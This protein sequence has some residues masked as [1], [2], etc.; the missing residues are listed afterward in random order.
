MTERIERI[1]ICILIGFVVL[2]IAWFRASWEKM[3][4]DQ[5]EIASYQSQIEQLEIE[6]IKMK[7]RYREAREKSRFE[8]RQ[9]Q[10]EA[11]RILAKNVPKDPAKAI[12][13]GLDEA[14]NFR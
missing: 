9:V 1:T 5:Q 14:Q 3:K 10:N 8:M 11:I 6:S 7:E 13:W 12:A 2:S 4:E